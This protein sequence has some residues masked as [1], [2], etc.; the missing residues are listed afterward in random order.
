MNKIKTAAAAA[1]LLVAMQEQACGSE[2]NPDD[3][4]KG[5]AQCQVVERNTNSNGTQYLVVD[6]NGGGTGYG[7]GGGVRSLMQANE[8]PMCVGGADWPGCKT[9]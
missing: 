5:T 3:P 7:P 9:Q 1:T 8:W 4:N 6:C 2:P